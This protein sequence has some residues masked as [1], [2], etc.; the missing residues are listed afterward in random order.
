LGDSHEVKV[1]NWFE[2]QQA[3]EELEV[4]GLEGSPFLAE[5]Y[6]NSIH[7]FLIDLAEFEAEF[8]KVNTWYIGL[9]DLGHEGNWKWMNEEIPVTDSHWMPGS[10]DN[11]TSNTRDCGIMMM[12]HD[13]LIFGWTDVECDHHIGG[14]V[15]ICQLYPLVQAP[16]Q[17]PT[18]P[19][20]SF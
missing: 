6:L 5:P 8:T 4:E 10:P 12:S 14:A 11:S 2:A 3:C 17:A 18:T 20:P 16:T 1:E 15:P 7:E 19:E 9:S 13:D